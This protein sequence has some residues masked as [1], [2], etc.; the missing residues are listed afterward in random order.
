MSGQEFFE[1]QSKAEA[2]HWVI[3][4]L[5]ARKEI[6]LWSGKVEAGKTTAMR[7]LVMA[8]CRGDFFLGA[9]YVSRQGSLCD[10]RRRWCR[11]YLEEFQRLGMNFHRRSCGFHH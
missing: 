9:P 10:A 3:E 7:T 11:H 4:G 5:L 8:V 1:H 6:S 2:R